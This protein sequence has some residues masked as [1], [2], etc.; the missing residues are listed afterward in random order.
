LAGGLGLAVAGKAATLPGPPVVETNLHIYPLDTQKFPFHPNATY[1]PAPAPLEPYLQFVKEA[2][3]APVVITHPSPYQD[4]HRVLEYCFANE[5]SPGFFKG[6]CFFDP[7]DPKTFGRMTELAKKHPGRVKALRIFSE[8]KLD[9]PPTK[10]GHFRD[11]DLND[12]VLKQIWKNAHTIGMA[13]QM[14]PSPAHA[15]TIYKHAAEFKDTTV[16]IDHLSAPNK[17][18]PE[19][20]EDVLKLGRLKNVIMKFTSLRGASKEPFP[21]KDLRPMAKRVVDAFGPDRMMWGTFGSNM[22]AYQRNVEIFETALDFLSEADK[23]K[24]RGRTAL[25]IFG[26]KS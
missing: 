22:Q 8:R 25:R 11:R 12:P 4:D 9:T 6:T 17:G 16:I 26:F 15:P 19:E 21:H 24:I 14:V 13:I 10:T 2:G 23:S 18:A 5:P 3:V 20:F 1:Q 7:I